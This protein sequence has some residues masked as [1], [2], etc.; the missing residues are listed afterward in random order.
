VRYLR[1]YLTCPF[2]MHRINVIEGSV[3]RD[4]GLYACICGCDNN[5][6][7]KSAGL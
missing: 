3:G 5:D 1:D 6:G 2:N 7:C 4:K